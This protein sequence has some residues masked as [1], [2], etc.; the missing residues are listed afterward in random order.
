MTLKD[1]LLEKKSNVTKRW[2]NEICSEYPVDTSHFLKGQKDRFLNPVGHTFEEVI[3]GLF[4]ELVSNTPDSEAS[5]VLLNDIIRIKAVQEFSPLQALSFIFLLK[6][7]IYKELGRQIKQ[8]HLFDELRLI[9]SNIDRMA[10]N[11]FNIYMKCREH[12]YE[13]RVNEVK[14]MTSRFLRK[15]N[16]ICDPGGMEPEIRSD[17]QL[18]QKIKG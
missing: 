8:Q 3:D 15:A 18:T 17:A 10:L 4:D 16:L 14:T 1:L 13:I 12:I 5:L 2:L 11:A 7:V 6:D 9:E